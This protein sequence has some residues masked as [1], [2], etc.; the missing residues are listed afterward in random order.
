MAS[1]T[2]RGPP[3]SLL[4]SC[5][6]PHLEVWLT[7][8]SDPTAPDVVSMCGCLCSTSTT[9]V[10]DALGRLRACPTVASGTELDL[11]AVDFI[12]GRGLA[13]LLAMR[14]GDEAAARSHHVVAASDSVRRLFTLC[15]LSLEPE[16]VGSVDC[17]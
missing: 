13:L 15:G 5:T 1:I 17:D 16:L 7:P 12:D 10:A 2:F 14:Q 9:A 11:A 4:A 6:E 8:A 3:R